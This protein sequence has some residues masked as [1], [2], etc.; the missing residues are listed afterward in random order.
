MPNI[1][2]T[3]P[4]LKIVKA[5]MDAIGSRDMKIIEQF[6]SKDFVFRTSP[7]VAELPDLPRKDYL[8]KFEAAFS[9]FSDCEVTIHE[10][11][12]APGKVVTEHSFVFAHPEGTKHD[13]DAV[14]IFTLAE[15]DGELKIIE[16]RDFAD[17]EKRKAF[18]DRA[19]KSLGGITA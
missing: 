4:Q 8:L 19:T 12:E 14:A 7:K 2:P 11:I 16:C 17:H 5:A 3:T 13:Y 10:V 1:D 18:Y 9:V 6:L 15:E